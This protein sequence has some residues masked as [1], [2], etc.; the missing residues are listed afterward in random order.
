MQQFRI[1]NGVAI[2]FS[3]TVAVLSF[4]QYFISIANNPVVLVF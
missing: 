1:A 4:I 2:L 3:V